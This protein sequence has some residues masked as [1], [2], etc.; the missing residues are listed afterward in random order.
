MDFKGIS[1]EKAIELIVNLDTYINEINSIGVKMRTEIDNTNGYFNSEFSSIFQE[2][3]Y[4]IIDNMPTICN[5]L[6][7]YLTR[8]SATKELYS[9]KDINLNKDIASK[10][11]TL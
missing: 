6:N 2:K 4:K 5:N 7:K 11:E 10:I 9:D 1:T 8:V 3:S